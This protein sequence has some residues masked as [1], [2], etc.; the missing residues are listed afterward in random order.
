LRERICR[1]RE[2][3][4]NIQRKL[5]GKKKRGVRSK[6]KRE[7]NWGEEFCAYLGVREKEQERMTAEE[8]SKLSATGK[9][10]GS[11]EVSE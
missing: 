11:R 5:R 10:R 1:K 9:G 8:E 7:H 2:K 3:E 4:V 6:K